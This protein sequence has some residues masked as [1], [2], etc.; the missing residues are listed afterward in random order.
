MIYS[1]GENLNILDTI[2]TL[3]KK[4][5]F[6]IHNSNYLYIFCAKFYF[7]LIY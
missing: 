7:L 1:F 4:P 2:M 5:T 3:Q 6:N